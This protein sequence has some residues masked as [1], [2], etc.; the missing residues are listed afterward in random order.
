MAY[1]KTIMIWKRETLLL[2]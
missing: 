2:L 1:M